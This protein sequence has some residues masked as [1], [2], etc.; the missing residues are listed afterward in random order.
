MSIPKS[1]SRVWEERAVSH[2]SWHTNI[3]WERRQQVCA[4]A[5]VRPGTAR[6]A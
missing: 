3:V 1:L 6:A 2:G 4:S 5:W